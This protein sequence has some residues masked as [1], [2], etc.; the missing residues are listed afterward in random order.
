MGHTKTD[1]RETCR[2]LLCVPSD[3]EV[4]LQRYLA[5]KKTPHLSTLQKVYA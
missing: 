4:N 3:D 5:H 2:P 1:S